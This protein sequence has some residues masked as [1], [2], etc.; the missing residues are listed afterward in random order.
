MVPYQ[1]HQE[2]KLMQTHYQYDQKVGAMVERV[3]IMGFGWG[4]GVGNYKDLLS[5][6]NH[7]RAMQEFMIMIYRDLTSKD[8]KPSPQKMKE[9]IKPDLDWTSDVKAQDRH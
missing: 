1:T 6:N 5:I 8:P 3:L 4:R 7:T 2:I 9:P